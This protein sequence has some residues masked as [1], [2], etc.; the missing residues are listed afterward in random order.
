M[1]FTATDIDGVWIIEPERHEDARGW[2]ARTHCAESFAARGLTA[3]FAQCSTSFNHR[4]GTLRGLHFQAPPAA[5]AKL[6][7]CVRGAAFD[8]AVDLRRGSPTLGRWVSVTLSGENGRAIHI[9]EGCAHGFQTLGPG[10]ELF[11]QISAPYAPALSRG[12]RWDDAD[13]AIAW[14][15]DPPIVGDRDRALPTLAE[16][17]GAPAA[18]PKINELAT[19]DADHG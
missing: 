15:L 13:I 6:I 19:L 2:F 10:C 14:P 3:D 16:V 12:V 18:D 7:R 5:E 9:P 8:V 4:A 1:N 11:Y 17:L